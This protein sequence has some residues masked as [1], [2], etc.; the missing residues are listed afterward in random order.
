[1]VLFMIA[2]VWGS[3]WAQTE[4]E[5]L[6]ARSAVDE[7]LNAHNVDVEVFRPY[8]TDDYMW[9]WVPNPPMSLE[10][11]VSVFAISF[12]AFPDWYTTEARTLISGNIMVVE[13]SA[14]ATFLGEWQ[15]M[16]PTGNSWEVPHLDIIEF[17][18]DKIKRWTTYQDMVSQMIQMGV[19]PAGELPPLVPSFTLPDPEPTGL[20]P[21]EAQA[22]GM[23]RWNTHD[24]ALW[25]QMIRPDVDVFYNVLGIPT[26]RD[27]LVALN[28][29][30][31]VGFSD[32][33]GE[34]VRA[35]D[36]GDGWILN[37]TIFTGTHDGPYLGV[38]A[39]GRPMI[40][41][42]AWV[43]RYDADGVMTHFHAYFDNLGVLVQIGA[44]PPPEPSTVSP[45][46]WGQIKAKFR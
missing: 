30:Y 9:E 25:A 16:A 28:E 14:G 15:G 1:M 7:A 5:M 13:H 36:L 31:I 38:P 33:Q 39:T 46:S 2:G 4:V 10:E 35:V 32:L 18:G 8:F 41:R 37:E 12:Q 20:S 24:L 43:A 6:A 21:M 26:D 19:M 22:E 42:L 3:A 44:I 17:E 23:A 34:V 11:S 29:M 45:A 40:N 27:G